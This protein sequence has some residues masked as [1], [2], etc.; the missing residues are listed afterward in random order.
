MTTES[1]YSMTKPHDSLFVKAYCAYFPE[2]AVDTG[3]ERTDSRW[4]TMHEKGLL[5]VVISL[6]HGLC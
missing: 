3:K 2:I 4:A 1:N 6:W 5:T